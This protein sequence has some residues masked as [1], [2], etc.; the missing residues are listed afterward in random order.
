MTPAPPGV[1]GAPVNDRSVLLVL[2]QPSC[3]PRQSVGETNPHFGAQGEAVRVAFMLSSRCSHNSLPCTETTPQ[4]PALPQATPSLH[5]LHS[6]PNKTT[7]TSKLPQ[8]SSLLVLRCT[9]ASRTLL[10]EPYAASGATARS[11]GSGGRPRLGLGGGRRSS[12]IYE[13]EQEGAY[14]ST[15]TSGDTAPAPVDDAGTSLLDDGWGIA[16]TVPGPSAAGKQDQ[17][18]LAKRQSKK[19]SKILGDTVAA[20]AAAAGASAGVEEA[21][22]EGTGP[23]S[24]GGSR[25]TPFVEVGSEAGVMGLTLLQQRLLEVGR[26]EHDADTKA[27]VAAAA[28][29]RRERQMRERQ[30]GAARGQHGEAGG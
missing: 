16:V 9:M 5:S 20:A 29:E 19:R 4:L 12:Q 30:G 3:Q 7:P 11:S 27:R 23:S 18:Q 25:G 17:K 15:S 14:T 24:S 21:V 13:L 28:A 1:V 22:S 26:A 6:N 10:L 2:R 8:L